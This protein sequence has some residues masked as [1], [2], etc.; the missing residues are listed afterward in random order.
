MVT[1]QEFAEYLELLEEQRRML[2][3]IASNFTL[4][5]NLA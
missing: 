1:K 2:S 5:V 3:L 4:T